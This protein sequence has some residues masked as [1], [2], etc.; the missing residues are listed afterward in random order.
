MA[1]G[2]NVRLPDLMRQFV[3]ERTQGLYGSASEYIRDLI[4]RDYEQEEKRRWANL[5]QEIKAG[6][7]ASEEEF[8]VFDPKAVIAAAKAEK[9]RNA[10]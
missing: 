7:E 9:A 5:H 10:H 8:E 2:I 1:E 3:E 6:M 4:R